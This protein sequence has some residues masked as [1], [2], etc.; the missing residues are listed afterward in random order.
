V[1]RHY[2][3]VFL[4]IVT[5]NFFLPRLMPGDPFLFLST[6]DGVADTIYSE[7]Q[8]A[9]YTA[10]YGL[11]KPLSVQYIRYLGGLARGYLG[12]SIYYNRDVT[13]IILSRIPW[14]LL[15]VLVSLSLSSLIGVVVGS[16]SAWLRRRAADPVIYLGIVVLSEVPAFL[17]GVLFLFIF[18]ARLR[19]FPLS[20]AVT[21]FSGFQIGAGY[22]AD[23]L[24]H[25][26]LPIATL[27]LARLGEFYLLAR[28]SMVSVL[29]KS[30][31]T[32]ARAKGLRRRRVVFVHALR[33]ALP[34]IVARIFMSLGMLFGGA[35]LVESV[36]D[37]PGIGRLLR[38]AVEVR[39]YVLIQ[40]V[41]FVITIAVLLM[42]FL[43]DLVYRGLDPRVTVR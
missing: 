28:S 40:G 32:T 26:V 1:R 4:V 7:N 27:A 42:N 43:A 35:V 11:D 15:I 38:E 37:Y 6:T 13:Q 29:T 24:R 10:Y 16:L 20:G 9:E 41:F 31:V 25:A 3:V 30:Y 21:P 14:T 2:P 19:W 33:N 36:F 22:I 17:L 39:D 23:V 8:I 34:P 18:A 12:Y 5:I